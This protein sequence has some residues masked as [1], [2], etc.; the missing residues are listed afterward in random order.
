MGH[1]RRAVLPH[2]SSS[3]V[4]PPSRT[5]LHLSASPPHVPSSSLAT[6]PFLLARSSAARWPHTRRARWP[7]AR[8]RL[9]ASSYPACSHGSGDLASRAHT[10]AAVGV[11]ANPPSSCVGPT[12]ARGSWVKWWGMTPTDTTIDYKV[13]SFLYLYS[14]F[15]YNSFGSICTRRYLN[16]GTNVSQSASPLKLNFRFVGSPIVLHWEGHNSSIRSA[17]EVN[18]YLIES[19][20]GFQI[21]MIPPQYHIGKTSKSS[22]HPAAIFCRVL[23]CRR[24]LVIHTWDPGLSWSTP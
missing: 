16:V 7:R 3:S 14:N 6:R 23:R 24:G 8:R 11:G 17:I 19:L 21:D 13:C 5:S 18:K 9:P 1:C 15:R 20:F 4:R 10:A 12:T 2:A 22:R